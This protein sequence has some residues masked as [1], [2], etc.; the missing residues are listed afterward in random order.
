[1]IGTLLFGRPGD[2]GSGACAMICNPTEA[3][4]QRPFGAGLGDNFSSMGLDSEVRVVYD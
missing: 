3:A 1:M 4:D 2:S